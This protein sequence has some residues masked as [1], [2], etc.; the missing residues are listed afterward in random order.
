MVKIKASYV[1]VLLGVTHK[2]VKPDRCIGE[3]YSGYN[4]YKVWVAVDITKV[5]YVEIFIC[6]TGY[7]D[8]PK[9]CIGG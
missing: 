3:L 4:C 9:R 5:S 8:F 6:V 7:F 2:F 1:E